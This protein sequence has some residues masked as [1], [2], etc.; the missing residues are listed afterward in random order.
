M[1]SQTSTDTSS[2]PSESHV[3]FGWDELDSMKEEIFNRVK[4]E[5]SDGGQ[6]PTTHYKP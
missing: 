4:T 6:G 2:H 5:L 1:E 3:R